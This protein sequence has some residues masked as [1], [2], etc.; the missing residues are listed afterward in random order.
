MKFEKILNESRREEFEKKFKASFSP[1]QL[2]KII[3]EIPSKY[4]QWVG[5]K[6]D[7]LSFNQN[8]EQI[9]NLIGY[10][11]KFGSNLVKT[12]LYQYKTIE[13]LK[14]VLD[15]YSAR[16]RRKYRQSGGANVVFESPKYFVVNPLSSESSCYYGKGTK[17]CT[18]ATNS[19]NA[20]NQYNDDGK[21]FYIL[22]K[23]IPTSDPNYK[24]G[25]SLKF[26]G[27]QSFFDAQNNN[28]TKSDFVNSEEI[29]QIIE[30][31]KVYLSEEYSAQIAAYEQKKKV[32]EE[33]ERERQLEIR[34]R[35]RF[36]EHVADNRRTE[37]EWALNDSIDDEGK[38]AWAALYYL[39][40]N[41][42]N[43][44]TTEQQN[45]LV[46]IDAELLRLNAE[47]DRAEPP[48]T[49]LLEKLGELQ[50]ERD[51][52]MEFIDVY[53][54]YPMDYDFYA[55]TQFEV[56]NGSAEGQTLAVGDAD[57]VSSAIREYVEQLIDDIGIT[58]FNKSF[59][60]NYL[61][62]DAIVE[63]ARD[64]YGQ[65]VYDNPE[66][67]FDDDQRNLDKKQIENIKINKAKI[68]A[69]E[70]NLEFFENLES[71]ED[72][73]DYSKKIENIQELI[74][75]LKDEIESIE[76]DPSGDFPEDLMEEK[77]DELVNY[78]E[79]NPEQ[80]LDDYGLE[81]SDFVN[82]EEFIEGVIETDGYG[83]LSPYDGTYETFEV[84]GETYYV[85]RID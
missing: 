13:E 76:S 7:Q 16:Q 43:I 37:N 62:S 63:N 56:L 84:L 47:Y 75:E 64:N 21:L 9:K 54:L 78:V 70:K 66:A 82:R 80:Y 27:S 46:E 39:D 45:R 28:V 11:D 67:Y 15:Q 61:D 22:N 24:I 19:Q 3:E 17:W 32:K 23:N 65:D 8:F 72:G 73:S 31:I 36:K 44:R 2:S 51:E 50:D 68:V 20:F 33:K 41:G 77:V 71:E 10:F 29:Q 4:W 25:Y 69:L 81:A 79:R 42:E 48:A 52:I 83:Q 18:A 53:D 5:S 1:D 85:F 38:K 34:R 74:D 14:D 49:E 55:L 60:M 58:G 12:D 35:Q 40:S 26:D 57:E 6:L 30:K 59:W